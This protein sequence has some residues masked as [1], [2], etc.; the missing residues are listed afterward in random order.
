MVRN[1]I[2]VGLGY[3]DEGKGVLTDYLVSSVD[4]A[5]VIRHNGGHQCGH[6]VR[7]PDGRSHVFSNF[8]AGTF[9]QTPVFFSNFCTIDPI[10]IMNEL[11]ALRTM[12]LS[13]TLFVDPMAMVVTPFDKFFNINDSRN[14]SHGTVGVGFGACVE[15][16]QGP[17][18]LFAQDLFF[19]SI[20]ERKLEVVRN[21]YRARVKAIGIESRLAGLELEIMRI[22]SFHEA[23]CAI[24]GFIRV[25]TEKELFAQRFDHFIFEGGQGVLLDMEFGIYP[26]MT[27][28]FTTSR[29]A[30]EI[31][32]RNGQMTSTAVYYATRAYQTRHGNG[33]MSSERYPVSLVNN[34]DET[35]TAGGFQGAFRTGVLDLDM[36]RYALQCDSNYSA[37]AEKHLVISCLDQ[38]T[39]WQYTHDGRVVQVSNQESFLRAVA[40]CDS[41]FINSSAC[42]ET[43]VKWR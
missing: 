7:M 4:N 11:G 10:G 6:T 29:N 3:G 43:M 21:H 9:R 12:G 35:N 36:L 26:N 22:D 33:W 25:M 34:Q 24:G 41:V 18:K 1:H 5:V 31:L 8:G 28:S 30:F 15:R 27:R 2:V 13:P 23:L 17:C 42:S 19:P 37:G 16:N 32:H 38:L 20:L 14:V 40:R 39:S